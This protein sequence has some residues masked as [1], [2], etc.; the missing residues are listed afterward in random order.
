MFQVYFSM[1]RYFQSSIEY[2]TVYSSFG[3]YFPLRLRH[4]FLIFFKVFSSNETYF[5]SSL[6]LFCYI[7]KYIPIEPRKYS[8][9]FQYFKIFS[10]ETR[11]FSYIFLFVFSS[12][13]QYLKTFGC[14]AQSIFL[15]FRAYSSIRRYWPEALLTSD[16]T[17]S[18]QCDPVTTDNIATT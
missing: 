8:Y 11:V 7:H 5:Q 4:F 3:R 15:Y 18:S 12:I 16:Q 9:N 2:I 17:E 13:F 6:M 14:P 10:I 1:G